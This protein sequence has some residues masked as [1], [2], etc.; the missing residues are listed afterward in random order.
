MGVEGSVGTVGTVV[1]GG[2]V[3]LV[4]GAVGSVGL[5]GGVVGFVGGCG[6]LVGSGAGAGA[7]AD[8]PP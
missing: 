1:G 5:V 4:G 2:S 8:F 7:A 3:G 6:G